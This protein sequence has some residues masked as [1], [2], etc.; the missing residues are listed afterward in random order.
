MYSF[1]IVLW[2]IVTGLP[3][4]SNDPQGGPILPWIKSRIERGDIS[5]IADRRLG[6]NYDLN[7]M[8]KV[9]EIAMACSSSMSRHRPSMSEVVGQLNECLESVASSGDSRSF[10][11]RIPNSLVMFPIIMEQNINPSAR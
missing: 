2:E 1:G 6:G 9:V 3:P 5:S 8:W 11:S 7:S 4:T 10:S